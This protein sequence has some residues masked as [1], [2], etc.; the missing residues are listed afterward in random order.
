MVDVWNLDCGEY[1]MRMVDEVDDVCQI[2]N[3]YLCG[4]EGTV[5]LTDEILLGC[6]GY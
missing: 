4:N 1:D 2:D 6:Q 3:I 5:T